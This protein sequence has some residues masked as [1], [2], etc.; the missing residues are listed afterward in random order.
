MLILFI[1]WEIPC[2][3]P[4][5]P[6]SERILASR[7]VL[8]RIIRRSQAHYF[9]ASSYLMRLMLR[10]G[11]CPFEALVLFGNVFLAVL[12][13]DTLLRLGYLT[14]GEIVDGT[15]GGVGVDGVDACR[16]IVGIFLAR[17]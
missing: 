3:S 7:V 9:L 2:I 17:P 6:L 11:R 1:F 16:V 4:I 8:Y 5:H 10:C 13:V 12:D 15:V 14:A